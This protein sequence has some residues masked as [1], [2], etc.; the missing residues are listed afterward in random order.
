MY[1]RHCGQQLPDGAHFCGA[2]EKTQDQPQQPQP[3][4][5]P[6]Q[7]PMPAVPNGS[8]DRFVSWARIVS[9]LMTPLMFLL[10][11]CCQVETT[12]YYSSSSWR[13]GSYEAIIV[14]DNMKTTMLI[15]M[16]GLVGLTIGLMANSKLPRAKYISAT[17]LVSLFLILDIFA[18]I[19]IV[20][21]EA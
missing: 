5:P 21:I 17:V 12:K 10:R 3:A 7:P 4:Q 9:I 19:A 6:Q 15:I 2:C 1:C 8:G 16:F 13:R 14:P 20:F 18:T 11:L